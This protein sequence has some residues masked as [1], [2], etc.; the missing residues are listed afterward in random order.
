MFVLSL[1]FFFFYYSII[2]KQQNS[3]RAQLRRVS[4]KVLDISLP[5]T[6]Q[7]RPPNATQEILLQQVIA[8][9]LLDRIAMHAPAATFPVP[10]VEDV[11]GGK[12]VRRAMLRR[13]RAAYQS[14][15]KDLQREPLYIPMTSFISQREVRR[16]PQFVCY[17]DIVTTGEDRKRTCSLPQ[18]TVVR[19]I[20]LLN[21]SFVHVKSSTT[22]T[23]QLFFF[24]SFFLSLYRCCPHAWFDDRE[25]RV[26][27][28]YY[29][30]YLTV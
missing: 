28:K 18:F 11:E 29:R 19:C 26:V 17:N 6:L 15:Q 1:V 23:Y 14:S 22:D 7:L 9:G 21:Y 20:F 27:A 12:D 16:L 24:I 5:N 25:P 2:T 8:A 30:G 10:K 3:L 4:M 13:L